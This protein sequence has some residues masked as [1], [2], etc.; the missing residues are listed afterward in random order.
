MKWMNKESTSVWQCLRFWE[1]QTKMRQKGFNNSR[2]S[3]WFPRWNIVTRQRLRMTMWQNQMKQHACSH[4]GFVQDHHM[5]WRQMWKPLSWQFLWALKANEFYL[6][7]KGLCSN[8]MVIMN[9]LF[10]CCV[11]HGSACWCIVCFREW[12]TESQDDFGRDMF[13]IAPLLHEQQP[14]KDTSTSNFLC[15]LT[16]QFAKTVCYVLTLGWLPTMW[17]L[18]KIVK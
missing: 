5:C 10:S 8:I 17:V 15:W 4:P 9:G 13:G 11:Q 18:T 12:T 16:Q 14:E 1:C 7:A 6:I 3:V 2:Q